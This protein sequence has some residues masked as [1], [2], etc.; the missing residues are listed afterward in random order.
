[1]RRLN[2][3]IAAMAAILAT[4]LAA[5]APGEDSAVRLPECD[6]AC[7]LAQLDGFMTA[8]AAGDASQL[9]LAESVMFTENN[10]P[11]A[12]GQGLWAT[13]TAVDEVGL[14]AA[15]P[16]TGN[17]AWF[18]SARENG[19]PVILAARIHVSGGLI[20]EIETVVHRRTALPAPFGDVENM[21]HDKEF[22][23]ILPPEQRRSRERLLAAADT[24]FDTV[25]RNDGQV[26]AHFTEDCARLENGISTTAP[27][28]GG[29]GGNAA[30]IAAGCREQ[31]LLGIYRINKRI[32]RDHFIVDEERGVVVSRGFF[33]HDNEV[34][35]YLLTN[36]REMRTALKWPNSIS[37]IEAFRI[38]GG[39]IQR[40]EAVFTY[41]P[42]F[43]HNPFWGPDASPP[44][45]GAQPNTCDAAC[46]EA[47][48]RSAVGAMAG[49]RWQGVNW[50]GKVG[51]AENSVGIRVGE[52]IWA[53]VT[54]VDPDPLVVSDPLTGKAVWIGRIEEHGQPAWAAMTVSAAGSA[55]GGIDALIRRKEYGPPYVE[56]EAGAAPDFAL[57][58]P[59]RRSLRKTIEEL[60]EGFYAA[61][62][63]RSGAPAI[64]TDGCRWHVN[65]L[66]VADCISPFSGPG[67]NSIEQIRDREI[68]AVDEARGLIVYRTFEDLPA[69][70]GGYPLTYQVV[71]L[72]SVEDGR[73]AS[74]HAYTSE[75]PFGMKPHQ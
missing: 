58:P 6:R 23:E 12:V 49:N 47:N 73:I 65:G 53:T 21:V 68:L 33:D 35:R 13:V 7:L 4:P 19:T 42:Y 15:D 43:M 5:Q 36:G 16:S 28:P 45:H 61:V 18:G 70:G 26:F 72:M 17:A 41:V 44:E 51:Y 64:F 2:P 59:E 69:L 56:P 3:F 67:L 52:G 40:I 30:A 24:Y 10:V 66:D 50:A 32:R 31:F 57:V 62:N 71:E 75:L 74:I 38:K 46:L 63:A 9:P 37:L 25:E 8:L 55:I 27:P 20:D 39:A 54:A 14:E 60:G 22:N 1:M 34:D 48:A 11:L 29:G